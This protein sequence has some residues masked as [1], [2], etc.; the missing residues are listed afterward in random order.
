MTGLARPAQPD[1]PQ[2]KQAGGAKLTQFPPPPPSLMLSSLRPLR[3]AAAACAATPGFRRSRSPW[4]HAPQAIQASQ[5]TPGRATFTRRGPSTGMDGQPEAPVKHTRGYA[6]EA[7]ETNMADRQTHYVLGQSGV[8]GRRLAGPRALIAQVQPAGTVMVSGAAGAL[9]AVVHVDGS[10]PGCSGLWARL[11]LVLP[12][13]L[14]VLGCAWACLVVPPGLAVPG[15]PMSQSIDGAPMRWDRPPTSRFVLVRAAL[16]MLHLRQPIDPSM[17]PDAQTCLCCRSHLDR[18]GQPSLDAPRCRGHPT[19][20]APSANAATQAPTCNGAIYG[21]FPLRL[22]MSNRCA[23]ESNI[24]ECNMTADR[25]S[26]IPSSLPA[27][28]IA[29]ATGVARH[30]STTSDHNSGISASGPPAE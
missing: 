7:S 21:Q 19:L 22:P 24:V 5:A 13:G 28:A 14:D 30:I 17:S 4:K 29:P 23:H 27:V 6:S 9:L 25:L 16:G 2:P 15:S 11:E 1:Q 8:S 26:D 20:A 10:L 12:P 3:L 18:Q